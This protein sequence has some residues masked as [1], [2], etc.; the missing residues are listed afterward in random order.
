[1]SKYEW[2]LSRYH[3]QPRQLISKYKKEGIDSDRVLESHE[4]QKESLRAV[5]LVFKSAKFISR[6]SLNWKLSNQAKLVFALGGDNHFQYVSHFVHKTWMLGI[7]S[8]PIRSDGALITFTTKDLEKLAE[9]I[10]NDRFGVEEW[11]RLKLILN[12][13]RLPSLSVSEI[14]IGEE[15]RSS[16]SRYRISYGKH[17]EVQKCSGLLVSTG[18]GSTGWYDA[19]CRYLFKNGNSF[20]KTCKAFNFLATEPYHGRLSHASFLHGTIQSGEFIVNSLND[21]KGI[22]MLDAIEKHDFQ[23]GSVARIRRG[24]ALKVLTL[25]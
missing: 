19:S 13:K 25:K 16:M 12:G 9:S 1:M 10:E 6:E 8:D 24:T 18:A 20:P 3:L 14:F 5:S 2:D 23:E 4:R 7:N 11:T 22:L 15:S 21:S 17:S